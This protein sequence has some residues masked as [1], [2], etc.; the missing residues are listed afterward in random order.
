MKI[1]GIDAIYY[2]VKDIT[3]AKGFW[4]RVIGADPTVAHGDFC[5]W[6]LTNGESFGLVKGEHFKP[7]SGVLFNVTTITEAVAELKAQGVK[8]DDDGEI[9]ESPVCYMAFATDSE[10]NAFILHQRK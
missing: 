4:T 5:E 7:G 9:E 3:R 10:G 6:T 1:N 8:F 2:S